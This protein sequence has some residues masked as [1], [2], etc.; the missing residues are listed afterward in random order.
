M[1][2]FDESRLPETVFV[3]MKNFLRFSVLILVFATVFVTFGGLR[4][5]GDFHRAAQ[6]ADEN[7]VVVSFDKREDAY[8]QNNLGVAL[9]EQFSHKEAAEGFRRALTLDPTLKIAQT[10][11]AIALFNAQDIEAAQTAAEIAAK[12]APEQLQPVYILGLIARN[13]NRTDDAV[14]LFEKIWRLTEAMSARTSISD[15]FTFS[16]ANFGKRNGSAPRSRRRAV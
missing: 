11:L 5:I 12:L 8:R 1:Q 15:K 3:F 16:S 7:P 13:Q 6:A 4:K 14:K 10:N 9:L 2:F